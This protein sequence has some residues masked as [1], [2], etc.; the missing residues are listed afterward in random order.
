MGG[1]AVEAGRALIEVRNLKKYY[2]KGQIKALD[3]VS[4]EIRAG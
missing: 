1:R 4:V 3:D 2:N